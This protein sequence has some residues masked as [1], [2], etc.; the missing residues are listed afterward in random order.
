MSKVKDLLK[1]LQSVRKSD[2]EVYVKSVDKEMSA[3][4]LTLNQQKKLVSIMAD[5]ISGA[6]GFLNTLNEIIKDNTDIEGLK[7]YDKVPI[8]VALRN[9]SLGSRYMVD[10]E[11]VDLKTVLTNIKEDETEFKEEEDIVLENITLSLKIPTLEDESKIL[12][13]CIQDLKKVEEIDSDTVGLLYM[14][15]LVKYINSITIG[16]DVIVFDDLPIVDRIKLI[17]D[18]P[19][20]FYKTL[21][22]FVKQVAIYENKILTV[23]DKTLDITASFFDTNVV[24]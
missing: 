22:N 16:E 15:E 10:D 11:E 18:L 23:G 9:S 5:G 7:V 24:E 4:E 6:V 8:I 21:S 2:V 20:T 14:F 13:K 3:K 19:L 17:E 1:E 12:K